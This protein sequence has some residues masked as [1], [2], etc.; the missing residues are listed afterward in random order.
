[1]YSPSFFGL[2]DFSSVGTASIFELPAF[3]TP[4]WSAQAIAV[5][6]PATLV[7][8]SEHIG[9]QVVTSEVVG[10]NLLKDPGLHRSMFADGFSTALSGFCGSCPTTTYGENIGVM[11]ITKV[12][13]VWV[14]GGAAVFSILLSFIGKASALI[15]TIPGPVMGGVS[16]LLYG[17]IGASGI[18]L[19][20]DSKIDY[21]KARNLAMTSVV[22]VVGLSGIAINLGQVQLKG[23]SLAAVVGMLLG[24]IMYLL[25]KFKLTNEYDEV[26]ED[27]EKLKTFASSR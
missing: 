17:M 27:Q 22:F 5:I 1:M 10:K 11:A 13:S 8:V 18:R 7:V 12:Y 15:Q 25:D 16:F 24:L 6:I 26:D 14:I 9:H 4:K 3:Q 20:V 2:V 19:M 23:M 21:S